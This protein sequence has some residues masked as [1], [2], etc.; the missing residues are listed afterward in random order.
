MG[1][2]DLARLCYRGTLGVGAR[3]YEVPEDA[4]GAE[5]A[6]PAKRHVACSRPEKSAIY[7]NRHSPCIFSA[8]RHELENP[9]TSYVAE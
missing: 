3:V 2:R 5:Q 8:L 7:M 4:V 9:S 6:E 1:T